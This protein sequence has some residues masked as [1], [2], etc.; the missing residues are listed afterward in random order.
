MD[1]HVATSPEVRLSSRT[2]SF[3]AAM[4]T[5]LRGTL[6][7]PVATGNIHIRQGEALI[8]GNRYT[9]NRGD[10]TMTSPFQTNPVLDVEA[11]TRVARYNLTI[12]VTGPIDRTKLA[13]RSDPPLP[14]EEILSLLALGYA[15]QQALM[16]SS[17]SQPF[18]AVGASALLSQALSSQVS[19]RVQRIFGVSRIRI[20]PN[21]LGPATAGGARITIEERLARDLTITYSTNTAA[22]QQRDIRLRWDISDRISLIGERDIN[23]VFGIEVRF[24]RRLK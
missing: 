7:H 16:S 17:G 21:L 11:T 2:L 13:Y 5:N 3:V 23:G 8:A 20:D 1:I 18:G 9:I 6:S 19:G 15:P 22:A 4:D 24:H 10:I 12:D 14:N